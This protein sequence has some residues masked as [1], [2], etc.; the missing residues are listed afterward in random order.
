M[1]NPILP[2]TPGFERSDPLHTAYSEVV[3][4]ISALNMEPWP[5]SNDVL[6]QRGIGDGPDDML[7]FLSRTD[8]WAKHAVEHLRAALQ[9]IRH[10]QSYVKDLKRHS[11]PT[12][13]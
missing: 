2:D 13:W 5:I 4:A 7:P 3:D 12:N 6:V 1:S 8:N 11:E 9:W 10:A